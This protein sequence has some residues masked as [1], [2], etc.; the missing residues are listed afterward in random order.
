MRNTITV[1]I[2]ASAAAALAA[3]ALAAEGDRAGVTVGPYYHLSIPLGGEAAGS[4][5]AGGGA[6]C[7]VEW[8]DALAISAAFAYDR[9]EFGESLTTEYVPGKVVER[10]V[11]SFRGGAIYNLPL[12][13]T[14][15]YTGGGVVVAR[16]KTYFRA[17]DLEPRTLFHPGLYGEVGT[18]VPLVGP[19][20]VDAGPEFVVLFGKLGG[21]YDPDER[22]YEDTGGAALYFGFK[23]GVGIYF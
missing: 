16:E 18:Y 4:S 3:P 13:F 20:V 10:Q 12:A 8:S 15:P 5:W 17:G 1:L 23:A 9:H 6:R 2:L 7:R 14:Y 19:L 21:D 11:L 22:R